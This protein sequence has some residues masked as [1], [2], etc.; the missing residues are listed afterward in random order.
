MLRTSV[1]PTMLEAGVSPNVIPSEADA[2]IDIRAL[3]DEDM[4]AF[5]AEMTRVIGDP[6][7]KIVPMFSER[8]AAPPSRLDTDMYRA[9]EHAGHEVY[10]GST[11]LP[12]MLT[13]ATDMA[14]LRAKGIQSYGIG[15]A[16]TEDE[17]T[18][19]AWHSDVERLPEAALYQFVNFTWDAITEVAVKK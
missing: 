2:T 1:V 4:T 10:P 18:N 11:V 16:M 15:P 17:R 5:L 6:A 14:Q 3:P 7:V 19:H 9:L 8:P 13:A 12:A